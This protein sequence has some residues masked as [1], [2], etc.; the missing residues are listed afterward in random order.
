MDLI[1]W[2]VVAIAVVILLAKSIYIVPQGMEYT[3]E[4]LGQYVATLTP[5]MHIMTPVISRIGHRV[6][7][8]EQ[9]IEIPHQQVISA[10]NA[11]LTIDAISY[12]HVIDARAASY[13]VEDPIEAI[14][15]LVVTSFRSVLG[16]MDLDEILSGREEINKKVMIALDAATGPWGIKVTRSEVRD[17][18][19]DEDLLDAMSAQMKAERL[20]RAQILEAQG[21]REASILIAEGKKQAQILEAEGTRQ[22]AFLSA[23]ARE[24]EAQAEAEST[25][26]VSKA[27]A[28]GDTKALDYFLGQKYVENM[29]L[30]AASENAKLIMLPT[31]M[32]A[33]AGTLSGLVKMIGNKAA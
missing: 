11:T 9:L 4:T 24:R 3:K 31:E 1:I 20:K 27:I 28:E 32:T 6:S 12:I 25:L 19:P 5:G 8:M 30:L 13:E 10:D 14:T 22:A 26:I 33:L 15:Q 29:G 2:A 21:S 7:I 23:E 17:L 16:N 18:S